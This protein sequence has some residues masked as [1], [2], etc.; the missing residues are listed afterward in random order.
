M[1]DS[2]TPKGSKVYDCAVCRERGQVNTLY[3][4]ETYRKHLAD[5]WGRGEGRRGH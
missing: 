1:T 5:H 4:R 2:R 3:S